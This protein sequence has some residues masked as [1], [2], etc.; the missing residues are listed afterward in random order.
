MA[1]Q[2]APWLK[3]A[4][5]AGVLLGVLLLIESVTT[6]H[7]V[8]RK[9]IPDHLI[10]QAG[11]FVSLL[12][13]QARQQKV[14]SQETLQRLLDTLHEVESGDVAWIRVL[15]Q[16]GHNLA[17]SGD[18]GRHEVSRYDMRDL[19]EVR[20][21]TVSEAISTPS[22]DVMVVALPFRFRLVESQ[23]PIPLN[24][25][26]DR[27][28]VAGTAPQ[29]G[30]A[31]RP[32]FNIAEVGL[33]VHGASDPFLPLRRNLVV[34]SA[35]A[36]ALLAAMMVIFFRL[37]IYLRGRA[38]EQQLALARRVQQELLPKKCSACGHLDF[39]AQCLP[40]WEVGGDYY[41]V[42]PGDDGQIG[43]VL[44]ARRGSDGEVQIFRL[45]KGGP[46]LGLLPEALYEE[47]E[48]MLQ[49]G[50]LLVLY[51]DGVVEAE[52]DVAEDFSEERLIRLVRLNWD[53]SAGEIH[54]T[55]V[56]EVMRFTGR[57][58]LQDDL[59]ML[60]ARIKLQPSDDA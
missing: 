2:R 47:E 54:R 48:V 29:R 23:A 36:L 56:D 14:E 46:V 25:P 55:I 53:R 40:A 59:T 11:Q 31:R 4:V 28:A 35:A 20:V 30:G 27:Q 5:V 37:P 26:P 58:S 44:L 15:D 1:K 43:L 19:L 13:S 41:D 16:E 18:P 33:Y 6:Y 42:L 57:N 34:S 51:S 52:N 50:D 45:E 9:L 49:D 8:T 38:L 3:A 12:E 24:S 22:G 21:Q 10:R 39:T 17:V 60:V 7:S 32:R